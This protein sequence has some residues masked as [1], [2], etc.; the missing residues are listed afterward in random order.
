MATISC[1]AIEKPEKEFR[2]RVLR[3]ACTNVFFTPER[4]E[5]WVVL[6]QTEVG[7]RRIAEYHFFRSRPED[8]HVTIQND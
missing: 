6:A 1:P 8:I 5:D 7:A 2:C 4:W 3:A